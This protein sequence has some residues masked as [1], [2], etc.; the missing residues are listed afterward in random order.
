MEGAREAMPQIII[1]QE[2]ERQIDTIRARVIEQ[3][4]WRQGQRKACGTQTKGLGECRNHRKCVEACKDVWRVGNRVAEV[5]FE[6]ICL[7]Y[8]SKNGVSVMEHN[9]WHQ[10]LVQYEG[11]TEMRPLVYRDSL[12][13]GQAEQMW[14]TDTVVIL[15]SITYPWERGD[16]EHTWHNG[17]PQRSSWG[18]PTVSAN[19]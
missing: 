6:Y 19:I 9:R 3:S 10:Q 18:V 1:Q 14:H 4:N 5:R 12:R 8:V 17:N 16:R 11:D 2:D 15:S 7:N 13:Q